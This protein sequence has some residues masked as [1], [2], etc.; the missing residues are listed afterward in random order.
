VPILLSFPDLTWDR[1]MTDAATET[2]GS[3]TT[4]Y[5]FTDSVTRSFISVYLLGVGPITSKI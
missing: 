3:H 2:E 5:L 1:Q 4:V